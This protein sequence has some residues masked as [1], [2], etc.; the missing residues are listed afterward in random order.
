MS[1]NTKAQYYLNKPLITDAQSLESVSAADV[2]S[3]VQSALNSP[4]T[5]VAQG[6]QVSKIP[7]IERVSQLL[8]WYKSK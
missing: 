8:N 4:L 6:G 5:L 1:L 2:R 3:A 7:S